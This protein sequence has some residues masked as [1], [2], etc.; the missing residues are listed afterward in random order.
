MDRRAFLGTLAAGAALAPRGA[1][2]GAAGAVRLGVIGCGWYGGVVLDA[3][4]KA[5]GVEAVA[6]C[7]VDTEHLEKTGAE[8]RGLPGK[9]AARRSRTGGSSST[10]PGLEAVDDRH[11]APLARAAR[12][13]RPAAAASTSTA[14]SPSPTTC[15]RGG[16]WSRRRRRAAGS[17]RSASSAGRATAIRQAQRLRG[18]RPRRDGSCPPRAQIHY[19]AAARRTRR[20]RTRRRRSTGTV[21][22][23]RA[24][25]PLQPAGRPLQLARRGGL[26]QRPPRGLGHPLDRRDPQRPRPGDAARRSRRRAAST[27]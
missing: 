20:R 16:P 26:R 9:R 2:F 10:S 23:P 19:A 18:R 8:G 25:A 24:E 13:S 11:P 4:F 22:R 27:A 1:A 6:L 21:V 14:R 5:G 15:A 12:S 3:A 17:C 7:D